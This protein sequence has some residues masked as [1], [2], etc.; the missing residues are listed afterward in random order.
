MIPPP[1]SDGTLNSAAEAP[2]P[3]TLAAQYEQYHPAASATPVSISGGEQAGADL[4]SYSDSA[5]EHTL[6]SEVESRE[7]EP[8]NTCTASC[9]L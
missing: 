1:A 2:P 8:N 4:P 3:Y 5:V 7:N 6:D 9:E